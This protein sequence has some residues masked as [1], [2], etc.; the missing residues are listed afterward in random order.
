[1]K[2]IILLNSSKADDDAL[3]LPTK[4]VFEKLIYHL[5]KLLASYWFNRK[6]RAFRNNFDMRRGSQNCQIQ[7]H[8][9]VEWVDI[10]K[11]L[12]V[13]ITW[14]ANLT[15]RRIT[16]GHYLYVKCVSLKST[17]AKIYFYFLKLLG[18]DSKWRQHVFQCCRMRILLLLLHHHH[19]H[20]PRVADFLFLSFLLHSKY[21]I[22]CLKALKT[23]IIFSV[24]SSVCLSHSLIH[25]ISLMIL[26]RR[27]DKLTT[28]LRENATNF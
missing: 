1:M 27:L 17:I 5:L 6:L 16:A 22:A 26:R 11:L 23:F 24:V 3:L 12:F 13:I 20:H 10:E 14:V 9:N 28:K 15:M 19:Y 21:I 18:L 7:T 2:L 4:V 8:L 25:Y